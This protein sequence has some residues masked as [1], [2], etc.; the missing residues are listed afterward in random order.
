MSIIVV[1][2]SGVTGVAAKAKSS[3]LTSPSVSAPSGGI[4]ARVLIDCPDSE[5]G[6]AY[7][8]SATI[9]RASKATMT[10]SGWPIFV[11]VAHQITS[12][13]PASA[14]WVEDG[15]WDPRAVTIVLQ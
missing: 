7:P 10:G 15:S 9:G 5:D 1:G 8:S 4:V 3:S 6:I 11:A 14:T 12:T 13:S 2:Y